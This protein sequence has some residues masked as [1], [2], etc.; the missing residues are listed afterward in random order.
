MRL[1]WADNEWI[2]LNS[3]VSYLFLYSMA[4]DAMANAS[5]TSIIGASPCIT[6]LNLNHKENVKHPWE[7]HFFTQLV[8][9]ISW[10]IGKWKQTLP[11]DE[12]N[13]DASLVK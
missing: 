10:R 2:T 8:S 5:E 6:C 7:C 12:Y 1:I 3:S 11:Q 13:Y 9:K 4:V